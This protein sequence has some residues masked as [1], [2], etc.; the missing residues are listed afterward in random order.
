ML[1]GTG[2]I[3]PFRWTYVALLPYF[4]MSALQ[5]SSVVM[6]CH[7]WFFQKLSSSFLNKVLFSAHTISSSILLYTRATLTLNCIG[8]C[9]VLPCVEMFYP[10]PSWCISQGIT[11]SHFD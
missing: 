5:F 2:S 8:E 11:R 3:E 1:S 10:V 4:L 6:F 7:F 9:P